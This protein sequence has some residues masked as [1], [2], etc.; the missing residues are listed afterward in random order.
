MFVILLYLQSF[1]LDNKRIPF[2]ATVEQSP[3]VFHNLAQNVYIGA[4]NNRGHPEGF[5]DGA[6]HSVRLFCTADWNATEPV[7]LC[8]RVRNSSVVVLL[9]E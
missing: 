3:S 4:G 8:C 9:K 2:K 1:F 5:F 7:P 6:L